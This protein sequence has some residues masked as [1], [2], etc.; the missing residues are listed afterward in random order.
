M[1]LNK[2]DKYHFISWVLLVSIALC[3]CNVEKRLA[4]NIEKAKIVAYQYPKSFSEFCS[5]SYPSKIIKG[6]DTL[7]EHTIIIKGDSIPCPENK[8]KVVFIKCRG[9]KIIYKERLRIDTIESTS[10]TQALKNEIIELT[11]DNND[12]KIELGSETKDKDK[13]VSHSSKQIG[14]IIGLALLLLGSGYWN[15]R[16]LLF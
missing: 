15:I 7:I 5:I 2:F 4:K 16:K 3:S 12:L 13:A 14:W 8:G 9:A 10:G 6:K 1:I 11:K